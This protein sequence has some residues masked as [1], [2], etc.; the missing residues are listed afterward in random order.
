MS[1]PVM[2]EKG[3]ATWNDAKDRV[4]IDELLH[5][6]HIGRRAMNGFKLEAWQTATTAYNMWFA[7]VVDVDQVKSRMKCMKQL[8]K[9]IHHLYDVWDS[10]LKANPAVKQFGTKALKHYSPLHELFQQTTATGEY[11]TSTQRSYQ[12]HQHYHLESSS[13]DDDPDDSEDNGLIIHSQQLSAITLNE[14]SNSERDTPFLSKRAAS[15]ST[16]PTMRALSPTSSSSSINYSTYQKYNRERKSSSNLTAEIIAQ[17]LSQLSD[18]VRNP[19]PTLLSTQMAQNLSATDK[20]HNFSSFSP[21]VSNSSV[22]FQTLYAQ[23]LLLLNDLLS[24]GDIP[25]SHYFA[26][27]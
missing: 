11:T 1:I 10:Y 7:S 13:S 23:V 3:Q 5:Q 14:L 19:T 27:S 22:A 17:G 4:L 18:S 6:V 2:N 12:K 25:I 15:S 9:I 24:L 20:S 26:A 21:P 8:H 16:L